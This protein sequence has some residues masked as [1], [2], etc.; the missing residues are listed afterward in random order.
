[1]QITFLSDG[2]D[3]DNVRMIQASGHHRFLFKATD[4]I[5]AGVGHQRRLHDLH[6]DISLQRCL[7][8]QKHVS[9]SAAAQSAQQ[10]K[11]AQ[12]FISQVCHE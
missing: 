1:M 2:I 6:C 11:L 9:H 10:M 5:L 4:H 12:L 3:L 8:R 7:F